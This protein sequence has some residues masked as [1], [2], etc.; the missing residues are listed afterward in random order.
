M[1]SRN[2]SGTLLGCLGISVM[3]TQNFSQCGSAVFKMI[4]DSF[5]IK[6]VKIRLTPVLKYLFLFQQNHK[7]IKTAD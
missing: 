7:K 4:K 6:F 2:K 1:W 5:D 3:E